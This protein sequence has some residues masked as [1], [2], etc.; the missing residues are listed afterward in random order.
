MR[1]R[2]A[3]RSTGPEVEAVAEPEGQLAR[4]GGETTFANSTSR[5]RGRHRRARPSPPFEAAG[6]GRG[7]GR[8]A[9]G[10][11]WAFAAAAR[12]G[13]SSSVT[14]SAAVIAHIAGM[15]D[16]AAGRCGGAACY[17]CR[18]SIL[19]ASQGIDQYGSGF[20]SLIL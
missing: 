13:S 10:R 6:V 19:H 15:A 8:E 7:F 20:E 4:K 14:G 16:A 12:C 9:L 1:R 18:W 3:L 11:G 5:R 17:V 2:Y